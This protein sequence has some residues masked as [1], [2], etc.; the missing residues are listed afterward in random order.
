MYIKLLLRLEAKDLCS[1]VLPGFVQQNIVLQIKASLLK[2]TRVK[3]E[4]KKSPIFIS[5]SESVILNISIK[6]TP[7][8]V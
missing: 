1:G 6:K 4:K 2:L 7:N 5:E 8:T 3:I